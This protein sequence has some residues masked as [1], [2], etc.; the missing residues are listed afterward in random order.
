MPIAYDSQEN[1]AC[2][3]Q[4]GFEIYDLGSVSLEL[5]ELVDKSAIWKC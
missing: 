4:Y 5:S 3:C 2:Q 1:S